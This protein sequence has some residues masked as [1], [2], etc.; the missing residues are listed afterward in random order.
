[1]IIDCHTHAFPDKIANQAMRSLSFES[2][3]L[4]PQTDGGLDSL[5]D[6]MKKDGVDISVVLGIATKPTQ[7]KNVNDFAAVINKKDGF[8]GF[9]S[10]HPDAEDVLD[11]LD[12]IK[13]LGLKGIKLHPE[14]QSFFVDDEKMKPIYTKISQLGLI[15]VFHAGQD[16]GFNEPFRCMPQSLANALKW[17]DSPVVA[18]HWGG[19][20]CAKDV[21]KHLCGKENLWFDI[22]F[23][24]GVM[25]KQFAQEIVEAQTP[26]KL[27]FGSDMPWHRPKWEMRLLESLDLSADD[28]EK[29]YYKNAAKLLEIE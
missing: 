10:I 20:G 5:R 28:K 26:D 8:V 6:E 14:Y 25:P 9:G 19:L 21:V 17:L 23:G 24:Y 27:L 11:E 7:Q 4:V 15:T 16:Y 2:G 22:S 18:A 1:M 13:S 3:G 29:I 12:R